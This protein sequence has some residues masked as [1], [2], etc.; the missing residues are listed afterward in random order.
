M[1]EELWRVPWKDLP[2]TERKPPPHTKYPWDEWFN[3]R[4]WLLIQGEDFDRDPEEFR[5]YIYDMAQKKNAK[6]KTKIDRDGNI[7]IRKTGG[8]GRRRKDPTI[9][10]VL[11][12]DPVPSPIEDE[13]ER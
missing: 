3:G 9:E 8:R 12:G 2:N 1:A 13:G 10:A 5:T 7:Y 11:R 4:T 6:V